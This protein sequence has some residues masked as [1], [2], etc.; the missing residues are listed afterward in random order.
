M[1]GRRGQSSV[2]YILLLAVIAIFAIGLLNHPRIKKYFSGEGSLFASYTRYIEFTYRNG[3]FEDKGK[4]W[5]A[6]DDY[7]GYS[8]EHDS[9]KGNM[10]TR[11]F[12]HK[13]AYPNK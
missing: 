3:Y 8:G 7:G 4:G 1:G 11:F 12:T 6:D 5:K 10:D 2:E 13:T 9:Y